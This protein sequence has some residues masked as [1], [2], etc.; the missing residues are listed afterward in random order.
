MNAHRTTVALLALALSACTV[1][2]GSEEGPPTQPP[3][4]PFDPDAAAP[5]ECPAA[6]AGEPVVLLCVN[7]DPITA[8]DLFLTHSP[9]PKLGPESFPAE[10]QQELLQDAVRMSLVL[11]QARALGYDD[12]AALDPE[13][14]ARYRQN[15]EEALTVKVFLEREVVGSIEPSDEEVQAYY[16][17][18]LEQFTLPPTRAA[19]HILVCWTGTLRCE[20]ERTKEEALAIVEGARQRVLD[21][22][23]FATVA[24][25]VSEGPSGPNGGDLGTNPPGQFVPAFE[26]ALWSLEVEAVSDPVETQFGWHLIQ[27]TAETAGEPIPLDEELKGLLR[28]RIRFEQST[29][30]VGAYIQQLEATA[31]VSFPPQA[32]PGA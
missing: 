1:T 5:A 24:M 21:G 15:L 16:L 8:E 2:Q 20:Q 6:P 4:N 19:R 31:E 12:A 27:A 22:E 11:Q 28:A 14:W 25:E 18:R 10:R 26:D 29:E 7:G 32:S 13:A 3:A 23:D 30:A 9:A 17:D